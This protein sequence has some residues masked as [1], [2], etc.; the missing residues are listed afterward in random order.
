[1]NTSAA[2]N[3]SKQAC[4]LSRGRAAAL[5]ANLGAV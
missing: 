4:A 3:R 5:A 2:Q 1:M